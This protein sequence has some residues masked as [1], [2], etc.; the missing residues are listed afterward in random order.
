MNISHYGFGCPVNFSNEKYIRVKK[1]KCLEI[2]LRK[3]RY[4]VFVN[5]LRILF[6]FLF[7]SFE[8]QELFLFLF[9][10]NLAPRIYSYSYLRKKLLF[11]DH[12]EIEPTTIFYHLVFSYYIETT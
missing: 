1:E 5:Y 7:A 12:W 10:Q 3:N 9:V 2:F 11:A 6:L 8:I 4:H